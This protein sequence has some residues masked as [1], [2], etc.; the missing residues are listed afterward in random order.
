[1]KNSPKILSFADAML[2]KGSNEIE[3]VFLKVRHHV[4]SDELMIN[5]DE[6]LVADMMLHCWL[7]GAKSCLSGSMEYFEL[8][9]IIKSL[10]P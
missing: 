7:L 9:A 5:V 4:P 2:E 3:E 1:M 6:T 8:V 10:Y